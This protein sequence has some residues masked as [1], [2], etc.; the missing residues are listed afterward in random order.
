MTYLNRRSV[1]AAGLVTSGLGF[2]GLAGQADAQDLATST[3][4]T[5]PFVEIDTPSGRVRG[6]HERGAV[7]FKGV[8]YAGSVSGANRFKAPPKVTPWSGVFDALKLGAPAPQTPGSTYGEQEPARSEDCLVLNVWTPAVKDGRKRPVM[9]YLHGGGYSTG[10]GGSPTQDGARL[11]A[12]YDVVVV[13][14]NHRLGLLGFLWL[15]DL[16]GQDYA[17]S[18]N[19]SMF[20]IIASLEWVRDHIEAFGGDPRNVTVFG[21]SGGGA[22]VG[23][24]LGMPQAKGLF[25][26]AG[27]QSGA[28]LRRMTRA[29]A[30]E[31]AQRLMRAL[32]LSDAR[33]LLDVPVQTLLKLQWA[34]ENGQGP[35]MQATP[36]FT[37]PPAPDMPGISF[38]E[39]TVPG[40]FG[41]VVDGTCL[42]VDPFDPVATP[43][44][45]DVPLLISNNKTEAAFFFMGQPEIFNMDAP[46]LEARMK[47]EYGDKAATV[48]A[49]YRQLYPVATPSQ[50]YLKIA[51]ARTMGVETT[52]LADRKAAQGAP[53]YRYRWDYASNLPVPGTKA[54]LGAGHATD[55][56]PTFANF[57]E[58]GL[59]GDGPGVKAASLNLSAI[60][61]SFAH[62]GKPSA[63]GVADWPAY[64]VATRPTVLVDTGCTLANDPDGVA[65]A[66]WLQLDPDWV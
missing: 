16:L 23:T 6:G 56:G 44:C 61:A 19:Q 20:D 36:G 55:I 4:I 60:W 54:T 57:D 1:M 7:A 39:S 25:H 64:A 35:L 30:A 42:P 5:A 40:H 65:R 11:A 14:P 33:K 28:Q 53:V 46:A 43:L 41:P 17:T 29:T 38:S 37:A 15:G 3:L 21:E 32:G 8:P 34:G 10:S 9:V 58:K 18:G 49:T 50:L 62:T 31:T 51:T 47:T 22:K 12:L 13:A 59:H 26:K 2:A 24:L 45:A 66:M 63:P 52:V 27:I 48:L